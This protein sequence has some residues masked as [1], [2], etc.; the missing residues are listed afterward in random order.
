[1]PF[2]A[3]N[4][5]PEMLR[6]LAPLSNARL[7][8]MLDRW[9]AHFDQYG[10]S[11]WAIEEKSSGALIGA[12]GLSHVASDVPFAPAVEIGWRLGSAW[13]GRGLARE[14]AEVVL[15]AAFHRFGIERVVSFTVPENEASWGLME[16]LGMRRVGTFEHPNLPPG[17]PLRHHVL[18]EIEAP[19]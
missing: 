6:H 15:D 8:A 5:E 2:Y 13:Q 7:D 11:Y 17:D 16:R 1:M 18:Y 4:A 9:E 3:L 12:C 19:H 14:A 10:Y